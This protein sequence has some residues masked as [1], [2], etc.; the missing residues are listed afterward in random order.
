MF[1]KLA[2]KI[3]G[4]LAIMALVLRIQ[5][6]EII[7]NYILMLTPISPSPN[8]HLYFFIYYILLP[9]LI[10]RSYKR[11]QTFSHWFHITI[12]ISLILTIIDSQ[13]YFYESIFVVLAVPNFPSNAFKLLITSPFTIPQK[14]A[15]KNQG[16]YRI[17]YLLVN[18]FT[19]FIYTATCGTM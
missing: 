7:T 9:V 18:L 1:I 13:F 12:F 10:Y 2:L 17:G 4:S 11:S 19:L 3:T 15:H 5:N 8:S 16:L 6:P 14:L